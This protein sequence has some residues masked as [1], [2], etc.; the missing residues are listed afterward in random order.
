LEFC[1]TKENKTTE[2]VE[3]KRSGKALSVD[4]IPV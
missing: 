2:S 3:V 1:M 4:K